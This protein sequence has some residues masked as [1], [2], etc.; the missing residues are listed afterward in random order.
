MQYVFLM[1]ASWTVP[2]QGYAIYIAWQTTDIAQTCV[3]GYDLQRRTCV[4]VMPLITQSHQQMGPGQRSTSSTDHC[5]RT[6]H[7][8]SSHHRA[9]SSAHV[10]SNTILRSMYR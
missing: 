7:R 3:L 9:S 8:D 6:N 10:C 2:A 5:T 1:E 4:A